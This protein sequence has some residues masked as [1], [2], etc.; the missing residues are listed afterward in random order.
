MQGT[1]TFKHIE[2]PHKYSTYVVEQHPSQGLNT[3]I[4]IYIYIYIYIYRERERE[5]EREIRVLHMIQC[6]ECDLCL[7]LNYK[8]QRNKG[9]T[10]SCQECPDDLVQTNP[11]TYVGLPPTTLFHSLSHQG[12][13]SHSL[14]PILGT[15]TKLFVLA[16]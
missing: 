16:P 12:N 5:R 7:Q 8:V 6:G 11:K 1:S 4:H 15:T 14:L 9:K 13:T 2:H 3:L 10:T